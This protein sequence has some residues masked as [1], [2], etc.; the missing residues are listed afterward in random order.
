MS[1][2]Y[3]FL[4]LRWAARVVTCS[5]LLA[6]TIT[7]VITAAIYFT[8]SMPNIDAETFGAL[9]DILGFW[10]PIVWS[11]TLLLSLFRSIK[12]IFNTCI[13]N[14][15][16]KLLTCKGDESIENIGYGD[17]V[18]VW[19]RWFMLNIWLVGSFMVIAVIYT[20]IFTSYNGVFEWFDI[21]W[22]FSFILVSG[23]FSFIILAS[24]C[25]SVKV[26]KC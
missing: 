22:L 17:L 12:Y 7:I 2:F 26:V 24:R 6:Y 25:K 20:S 8:G 16:L 21:Y 10:F 4:W 15:E 11:F 18:K 3:F 13:N 19:R 9:R 14:Y 1:K 5:V 23:Y